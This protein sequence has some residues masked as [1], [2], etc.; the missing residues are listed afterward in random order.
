MY[1]L[2]KTVDGTRQVLGLYN[3][4]YEGAVAM[5]IYRSTFDDNSELTLEQEDSNANNNV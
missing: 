3:S 5:D 2:Y 4:Q 1:T